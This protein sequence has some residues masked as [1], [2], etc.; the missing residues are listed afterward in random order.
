MLCQKRADPA[1]AR[2]VTA[3]SQLTLNPEGGLSKCQLLKEDPLECRRPVL[4][5][6]RLD[7]LLDKLADA[8]VVIRPHFRQHPVQPLQQ[9]RAAGRYRQGESDQQ[10]VATR[11]ELGGRHVR[12]PMQPQ[13]TEDVR[14]CDGLSAK[15]HNCLGTARHC[16]CPSAAET[17]ALCPCMSC[18]LALLQTFAAVECVASCCHQ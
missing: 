3:R 4:L 18:M 15:E 11:V 9:Q 13:G 7:N 12:A 10:S 8:P 1:A 2:H 6:D 5:D 17:T 14:S 16:C